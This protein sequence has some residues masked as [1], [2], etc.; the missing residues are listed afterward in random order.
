MSIPD[1]F[2]PHNT[3]TANG[4]ADLEIGLGSLKTMHVQ[5]AL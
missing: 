3:D 1:C 4:M 2:F 5:V